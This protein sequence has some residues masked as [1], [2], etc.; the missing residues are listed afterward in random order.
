MKALFLPNK[1]PPS[2]YGGAG[3]HVDYLSRELAKLIKVDVRGADGRRD[4]GR[5]G[6]GFPGRGR[7]I[8]LA[9]RGGSDEVDVH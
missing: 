3:V 7:E 4:G 5:R 8:Q 1:Y 9:S 2:I 6:G